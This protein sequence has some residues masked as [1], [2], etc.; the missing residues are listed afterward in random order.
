MYYIYHIPNVKIGCSTNPK[1]R[2]KKQGYSSFKI[3]ETHDCIDS[4][5]VREMELQ[6][7]Y[8]YTVDDAL[9]KHSIKNLNYARTKVDYVACG[10][11]LGKKNVQSGHLAKIRKLSIE[12]SK[13]TH[14]ERRLK[15]MKELLDI[16]P[17]DIFGTKD[18]Y[19]A[20]KKLNRS[21]T[22]IYS[23][24]KEKLLVQVIKKGTSKQT[25]G[26]YKKINLL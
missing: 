9:Y 1:Q 4:A 19:D 21:K 15:R 2:V 14:K 13:K 22:F 7:E 18:I 6:K 5:S 20:N 8:G 3:L 10:K 16:I 17:T 23:T 24:L 12:A 25:P 26:I 11:R